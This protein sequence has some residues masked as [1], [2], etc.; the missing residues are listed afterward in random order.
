MTTDNLST[1]RGIV[2]AAICSAVMWFVI[3]LTIWAVM[4]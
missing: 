4:Q 3:F 1:A 2:N